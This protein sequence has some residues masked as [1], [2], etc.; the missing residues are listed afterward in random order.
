MSIKVDFLDSNKATIETERTYTVSFNS[1]EWKKYD[2]CLVVTF[3]RM[4]VKDQMKLAGL[5]GGNNEK[6]PVAMTELFESNCLN[7]KGFGDKEYNG[8]EFCELYQKPFKVDGKDG[9]GL[10][11]AIISDVSAHILSDGNL[12]EEERKN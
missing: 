7:I 11:I 10:I 4:T 1:K 9:K 3:K 5:I 8:K 12:N 6:L 2:N